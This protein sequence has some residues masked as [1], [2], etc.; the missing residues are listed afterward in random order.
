MPSVV[1]DDLWHELVLHTRD[2]ADFCDAAFGR[3]LHHVPD[4]AM[5]T[6]AA[7]RNRDT[8]LLA[9]LRLAR[10]DERCDPGRLPL[11]FRVDREL[12]VPDGR[13]YLADCGGR[14]ECYELAGV[15]CL[16]HLQGFGQPTSGD[17]NPN[18]FPSGGMHALGGGY[19]G[20]CGGGGCG[21]G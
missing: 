9:T 3:F 4:P 17:S 20:G 11:L 15:L 18:R 13:R 12:A 8:A 5:S 19:G 10:Q 6:P 21:G 7:A 16:Q 1:V 14:G 2:Y